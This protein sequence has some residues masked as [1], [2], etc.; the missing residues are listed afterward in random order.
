MSDLA[1]FISTFESMAR[2]NGTVTWHEDD[3]MRA[4]GYTTNDAFRKVIYRAMQACLS[5][6]SDP[7]ADFIRIGEQYKFTRVACYLIA[8]S[9]DNRKPQVAKVQVFLAH[10]ANAVHDY[11][12]HSAMVDRVVIREEIREGMKSLANTASSH[13]VMNYGSFMDEGYRGMY[14]MRLKDI[15]RLKGVRPGEHLIDRMNRTELAENLFRVTLTD[16]KI[17]KDNIHGQQALETTAFDVGRIVRDAVIKAGNPPPEELP[18]AEHINDAKKTLKTAGN[19]LKKIRREDVEAEIEFLAA[20]P[21][22]EA[23][24]GYTTDPEEDAPPDSVVPF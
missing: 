18:L 1:N 6:N 10:F 12:A 22:N 11:Y 15:E 13:G 5:I 17:K 24:P 2:E 9:A 7:G 4:L 23:D 20:V 19:Q 21:E 8:M 16:D 3:L 14:N